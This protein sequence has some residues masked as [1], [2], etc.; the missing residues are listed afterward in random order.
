MLLREAG[1]VL[2]VG[3]LCLGAGV[4]AVGLAVGVVGFRAASLRWMPRGLLLVG[5]GIVVGVLSSVV[6]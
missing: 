3:L 2:A 1:T 6:H 5:C 4:I